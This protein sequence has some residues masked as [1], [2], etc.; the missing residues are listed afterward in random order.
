M[1]TGEWVVAVVLILTLGAVLWYAWEARK[2]AAASA[3]VAEAALRPVMLLWTELNPAVCQHDIQ[4]Y[5][6]YYRNIG[7]GP[8]INISF[9][10]EPPDGDWLEPSE[11]VGMGIHEETGVTE[12][13]L[14]PVPDRLSVVAVYEDPSHGRW[15]TTLTLD[16]DSRG[17]LGNGESKVERIGG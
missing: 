3:R 12:I 14:A 2:Q 17:R 10:L 6:V 16:K 11:R 5:K 8:A 4:A 13:V 7:S 9:H 1:S 15:K